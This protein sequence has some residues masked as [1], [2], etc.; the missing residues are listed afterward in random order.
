MRTLYGGA[1]VFYI[2]VTAAIPYLY[3]RICAALLAGVLAIALI[4]GWRIHSGRW[5]Y[6][7]VTLGVFGSFVGS[8]NG[9]PGVL[10][11]TTVFV[12]E[13]A[14]VGGFFGLLTNAPNWRKIVV[15]ALDCAV[16][17]VFLLGLYV[18]KVQNAGGGVP[19]WLVDPSHDVV[20][21]AGTSLRTNFQ[22]YNSLVFLAPYGIWRVFGGRYGGP[23]RAALV[24]CAA[25]SSTLLSGRRILYIE[26]PFVIVIMVIA[27]VFTA[28]GGTDGRTQR[29]PHMTRY[30]AVALSLTAAI[31]IAA[32]AAN[33]G[34]GEALHRSV[35]Q[36]TFHD[37]SDVRAQESKALL[38]SW[39]AS[40]LW[41]HGSGAVNNSFVR[42]PVTPWSYELTYHVVLMD[43]GLIGAA[44][45]AIWAVWM[46]R[47]F[48]LHARLDVVRFLILAGLVGSC[49]AALVDPY[50]F[51]IDGMWM[52]FLPFGVAAASPR[53]QKQK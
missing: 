53:I 36:V 10:A 43:F 30:I 6:I 27:R 14:I 25:V 47:R 17:A 11:T 35:Q 34:G 2:V 16:I 12:L 4:A 40:P 19:S 20:D 1:L 24:G 52:V 32:D 29:R 31:I 15:F 5:I 9:N 46:M 39:S 26:I 37:P 48:V 28:R 38:A 13:P 49:F 41:G 50:F 51:K 18:Y 44:V 45:L 21:T 7:L 8:I 22:G 42:D 33:L 23:L 3:G